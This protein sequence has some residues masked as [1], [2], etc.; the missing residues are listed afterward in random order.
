MANTSP[1]KT[2]MNNAVAAAV[3]TPKSNLAGNSKMQSSENLKRKASPGDL[4]GSDPQA[5]KGLTPTLSVT[6]CQPQVIMGQI[7]YFVEGRSP[8]RHKWRFHI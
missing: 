6:Y 4:I 8:S 1:L 5:K 7:I 2:I 3:A